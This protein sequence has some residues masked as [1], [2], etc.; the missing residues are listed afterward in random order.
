MNT[1]KIKITIIL[2]SKSKVYFFV[3]LVEGFEYKMRKRVFNLLT[4]YEA[5]IK[6]E[7]FLYREPSDMFN[8]D[9]KLISEIIIKTEKN[10]KTK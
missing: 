1:D 9:L 10:E 4:Q 6:S 2:P 5:K 8:S 3:K 7:E